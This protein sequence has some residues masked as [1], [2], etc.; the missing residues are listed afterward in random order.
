MKNIFF[1]ILICIYCTSDAQIKR[2]IY[3][4]T[5]VPDATDTANKE[6]NMMYLDITRKGSEFFDG[7]KYI[8]DS[9]LVSMA[10]KISLLCLRE[11]LNLLITE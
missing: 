6:I 7:H 11:M 4:Y 1:I 2:F 10:K 3:E 9:T 5:T 8:S